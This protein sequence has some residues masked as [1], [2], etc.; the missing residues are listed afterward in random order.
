MDKMVLTKTEIYNTI[1]YTI[2]D[3]SD[4]WEKLNG[5]C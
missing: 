4:L 1:V 2:H 5:A 3:A